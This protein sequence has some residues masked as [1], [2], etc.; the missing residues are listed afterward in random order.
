MYN[1]HFRN[2]ETLNSKTYMFVKFEKEEDV[3]ATKK[4]RLMQLKL[5][6]KKNKI[7]VREE[8]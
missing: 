4:V 5:S 8:K 1:V 6:M 7:R 3:F 2:Q